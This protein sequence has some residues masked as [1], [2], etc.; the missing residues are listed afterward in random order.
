ML[1]WFIPKERC[2]R[3]AY[4]YP[5]NQIKKEGSEFKRWKKNL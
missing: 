5:L 1:T 2:V 4:L 3:L